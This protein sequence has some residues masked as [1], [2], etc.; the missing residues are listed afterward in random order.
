MKRRFLAFFACKDGWHLTIG[1]LEVYWLSDSPWH[2]KPWK[3][4]FEVYWL[5]FCF[6]RK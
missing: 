6:E 2:W 3:L 4:M 5:R 1:H